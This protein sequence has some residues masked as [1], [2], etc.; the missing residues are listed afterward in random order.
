MDRKAAK[1][2]L[3]IRAWLARINRIADEGKDAYLADEILQEAGDS[4]MMKLG[5]ASKRL[6]SRGV[7]APEGVAWVLAIANRNFLIHQYDA[8]DREL[9]WVTLATDLPGWRDSLQP[10]FHDAEDDLGPGASG[11]DPG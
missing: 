6:S 8:I 5:E 1:D 3:H 2:L 7:I 9:T 11:S 10:L 4:L